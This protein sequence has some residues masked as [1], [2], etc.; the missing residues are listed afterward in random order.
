MK[1]TEVTPDVFPV[2]VE[3]LGQLAAASGSPTGGVRI[4]LHLRRAW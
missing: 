3:N 2:K 1:I 4:G